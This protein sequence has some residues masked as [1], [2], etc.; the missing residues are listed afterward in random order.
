MTPGAPV[1]AQLDPNSLLNLTLRTLHLSSGA[2]TDAT[3]TTRPAE[4]P[5]P[6]RVFT[7]APLVLETDAIN[8]LLTAHAL[9]ASDRARLL[10]WERAS[11]VAAMANRFGSS[12]ST[13]TTRPRHFTLAPIGT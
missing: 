9:P 8:A 1:S 11:I 6:G 2:T 7:Y 4:P 5:E 10:R 13:R 3:L 12:S